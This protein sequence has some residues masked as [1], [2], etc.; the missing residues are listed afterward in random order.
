MESTLFESMIVLA[1]LTGILGVSQSFYK[2]TL[3][4]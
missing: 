4:P 1:T 3:G 2:N